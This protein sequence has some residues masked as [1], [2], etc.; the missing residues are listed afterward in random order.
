MTT[1]LMQYEY[2]ISTIQYG[3][4]ICMLIDD[5]SKAIYDV[6]GPFVDMD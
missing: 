3:F 2:H 6:V 5:T 4:V 1:L